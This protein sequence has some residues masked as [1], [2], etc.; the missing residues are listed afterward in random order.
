MVGAGTITGDADAIVHMRS[1]DV[2]SLE[3]ALERVREAPNVE[4]TRSAIV[5][6]RLVDREA[7]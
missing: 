2:A 5:L 3:D 1:R 4:H 6:S 7:D